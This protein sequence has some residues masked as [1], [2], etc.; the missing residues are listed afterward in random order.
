MQA[1][2]I[3]SSEPVTRIRLRSIEADYRGF[4]IVARSDGRFDA[5]HR[6]TGREYADSMV[7]YHE[8][9]IRRLTKYLEE[10]HTI[11]EPAGEI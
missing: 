8:A 3:E 7:K 6:T 2:T 5:V 1:A 11:P 4:M 10:R 9:R